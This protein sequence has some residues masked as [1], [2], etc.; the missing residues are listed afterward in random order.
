MKHFKYALH[1]LL[2]ALRTEKNLRFHLVSAIVVSA[3]GI[4]F[5]IEA[6]E[7]IFVASCI[8]SVITAELFNTAIEKVCD[9]FTKEQHTQIKFIKD[10]SAA[11]VFITSAGAAVTGFVIFTPRLITLIQNI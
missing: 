7:W 3:A 4:F 1:G 9:V 6:V 5:K 8:S 2:A 11:A 10:V